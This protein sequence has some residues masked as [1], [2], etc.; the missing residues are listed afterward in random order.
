MLWFI[1]KV[2]LAVLWF[3]EKVLLFI[4]KWFGFFGRIEDVVLPPL[5]ALF[6]SVVFLGLLAG[7][8]FMVIPE[9]WALVRLVTLVITFA[10]LGANWVARY[11]VWKNS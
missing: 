11:L 7:G 1:G 5:R 9:S 4:E 6:R 2:L 10:L 8:I 3:I